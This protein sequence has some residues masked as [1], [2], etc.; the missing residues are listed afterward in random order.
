MAETQNE[1]IAWA[2][3]VSIFNGVLV[4]CGGTSLPSLLTLAV[5]ST[6]SVAVLLV[7][8]VRL[9]IW[10]FPS[11][12]AY[13]GSALAL[14]ALVLMLAQ[15][16]PLPA[17]LVAN[18]PGHEWPVREAELLYT[19]LD[20]MTLSLAPQQTK[21]AILAMLPALASYF[22]SLSL[23]PNLLRYPAFVIVACALLSVVLALLQHFFGDSANY[24]L[25]DIG[26]GIGTGTFNN[27]NF[28]AAQIYVSIPIL[29]AF[30]SDLRERLRI[31]GWLVIV[32]GF[33]YAG[34]IV[35][36]LALSGSRMGVLLSAPAIV[37]AVIVARLGAT[38]QGHRNAGV[39]VLI[40]LLFGF[41][42]LTQASLVG[43]LRIFQTDA[44]ADYRLT[45]N[46][47]SLKLIP[48]YFPYG[49]GF[50]SFMPIYQLHETPTQMRIEIVNHAHNDWFELLIEGGLPVAALI[51]V[52]LVLF[53]LASYSVWR[54]QP[55]FRSEVIV[56]HRSCSVAILLLL[57]HSLVD[58]PLRTPALLAMFGFCCAV[59]LLRV[60]INKAKQ[61][62]LP[63]P[64]SPDEGVREMRRPARS[65]D[66]FRPRTQKDLRES[67]PLQ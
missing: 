10:G 32:F 11:K 19:K 13:W 35:V 20:F 45:I 15:L 25:Y 50:G 2:L 51:L 40:S 4:L 41:L 26:H 38:S 22:A 55:N 67:R 59:I 52:F 48:A 31:V 53:G 29:A 16:V 7:A 23:K 21:I 58:Y 8:L 39:S 64:Q 9:F 62:S 27:Q 18:L 57:L 36:G 60:P 17:Y 43:L 33:V 24:Y 63:G 44:L 28:F 3:V 56:Y 5:Q 37:S 49:S 66:M 47:L 14:F 34:I 61:N 46:A 1:G 65:K 42:V 54:C 30:A 12:L 6:L